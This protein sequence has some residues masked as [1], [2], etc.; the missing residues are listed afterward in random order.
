MWKTSDTVTPGVEDVL[1]ATYVV[2]GMGPSST[3]A[4]TETA[5][6][7]AEH[8][9]AAACRELGEEWYLPSLKE[10][11]LIAQRATSLKGDYAFN[12]IPTAYWS[13]TSW[14]NGRDSWYTKIPQK[15][16][17]RAPKTDT[18]VAVRCVRNI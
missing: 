18:S 17:G 6:L 14:S 4:M 5:A 9:A 10:L 2:F 16:V 15:E 1:D 11:Q 8:P 7:M 12:R 3:E 13:A